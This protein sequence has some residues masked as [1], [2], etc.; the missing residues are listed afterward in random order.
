VLRRRHRLI[1]DSG[2]D[3]EYTKSWRRI[4]VI[5]VVSAHPGQGHLSRWVDA[6]PH[7]TT[8]TF[9]DVLEPGLRAALQDAPLRGVRLCGVDLSEAD[10]RGTDLRDADL[11]DCRLRDVDL[12]H[13]RVRGADLRGAD[14][15]ALGGDS[16]RQLRGAVISTAQAADVCRALELT[17]L[18]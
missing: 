2:L 3:I 8:I 6:L 7:D 1:T 10:L 12:S 15:G 9:H 14:L 4:D 17:V 13:T 11:V 18:D 5:A 16:P